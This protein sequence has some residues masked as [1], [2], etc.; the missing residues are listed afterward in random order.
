MTL[1]HP[2]GY[3]A[4]DETAV[5]QEKLQQAQ[6][7]ITQALAQEKVVSQTGIQVLHQ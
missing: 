5:I 7:G 6:I 3:L 1:P 2:L 4:A